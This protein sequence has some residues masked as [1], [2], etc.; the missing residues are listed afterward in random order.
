MNVDSSRVETL[1]VC[2]AYTIK[3][4]ASN[5]ELLSPLARFAPAHLTPAAWHAQLE[6]ASD[7]L[8]E[9]VLA[10]ENRLVT[11]DELRRRI[12][13][14]NVTTW[15]QLADRV[16]PTIGLGVSPSDSK[17]LSKLVTAEA[18]AAAIVGRARGTWKEGP[19]PSPSALCDAFA[20]ERL[21]LQGR[22]KR[23]PA[24]VRGLFLQRELS[25]AASKYERLL[26][27]LAARELNVPRT[28]ARALR[29]GIVRMWLTGRDIGRRAP[30]RFAD[31]VI[32]VVRNAREGLFGDRKVFI[33]EVWEQLRRTT[34]W[35]GI[36]LDDFKTQLLAAHR[37]GD[38]VLARADL[39]AAMN[40]TLVAASETT[41]NGASFHF[42]VRETP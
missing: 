25:T 5:A 23:L 38:V 36:T 28:D 10:K 13:A 12:G 29:D 34:A 7:A 1:I 32:A 24:E 19:P 16:L 6:S 30:A 22:A 20:W 18:W 39:V 21:G 31:E 41:A 11:Q 2:R 14:H 27:Q 26:R 3:E 4:T 15:R 9:T 8:R 42:V 37:S 33:S 40:P 17:T 35:A